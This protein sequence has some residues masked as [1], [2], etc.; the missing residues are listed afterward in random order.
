MCSKDNR[1]VGPPIIELEFEKNILDSHIK[2]GEDNIELQ[3]KKLRPTLFKRLQF[4]H[5]KM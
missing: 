1:H 2:I 3:M 5:P 4:G